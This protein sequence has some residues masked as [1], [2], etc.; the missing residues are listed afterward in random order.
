MV[1]PRDVPRQSPRAAIEGRNHAIPRGQRPSVPRR[2]RRPD[3]PPDARALDARVPVRGGRRARRAA[4][5]AMRLLGEELGRLSRQRRDGS[6]CSDEHCPHRRASLALG[7]NEECG[8]RCLYHGW[9]IDVEGIVV[10]MPVGAARGGLAQAFK[11]T[12]YPCREAGG[13]VWVWMGRPGGDA[14]RLSPR[15]G[16]PRP[17]VRTSIVKMHDR[18]QL[19]AGARRR[20]RFGAQLEPAFDRHGAGVESTAPGATPNEW[21]RPST[22]KAPRLQVQRTDFGFRY[23]AIRRPIKDAGHARLPA[24]HAVRRAVHGADP[25]ERSLQP[26][27]SQYPAGRHAHDVLFHRLERGRGHRP[28]RRGASSA[29]RRVG[30]D[31]DHDYRAPAHARRTTTCRIA[32]R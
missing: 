7:R 14:R 4:R 12:A 15:R 8:L 5:Y 20:D 25:A 26:V 32:T 29:V 13:F 23:V 24:H 2:R 10:D 3:G 1:C 16:R 18:L 22:D 31:L 17:A 21:P 30:I 6:A 11:H 28:G 9:K 19:G 27:D